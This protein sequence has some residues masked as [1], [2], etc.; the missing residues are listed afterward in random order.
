[1]WYGLQIGMTLDVV[2]ALPFAT[3]Q[4]LIAIHQIKKEGAKR[5]HTEAEEM[6]EF[7]RLLTFT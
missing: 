1:M 6:A 2:L 5:K 4:D 3:L 7:D